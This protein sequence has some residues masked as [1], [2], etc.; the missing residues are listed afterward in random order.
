M[1]M[2]FISE[3]TQENPNSQME[4]ANLAFICMLKILTKMAIRPR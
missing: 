1:E 4:K 2:P 3:R